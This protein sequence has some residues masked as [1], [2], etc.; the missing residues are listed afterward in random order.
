MAKVFV[1]MEVDIDYAAQDFGDCPD[2][3]TY[4]SR[5]FK[6]KEAALDFYLASL[7]KRRAKKALS[8]LKEVDFIDR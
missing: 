2:D 7:P 1:E 6:T 3:R 8:E 4:P 5:V